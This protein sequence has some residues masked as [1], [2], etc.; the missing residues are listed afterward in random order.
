MSATVER[1]FMMEAGFFIRK[2]LINA[3]T[4]H[5][6]DRGLDI[7]HERAGSTIRFKVSGPE[8]KVRLMIQTVSLAFSE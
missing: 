6:W 5:A 2:G 7:S 4:E 8:D 1:S 3:I